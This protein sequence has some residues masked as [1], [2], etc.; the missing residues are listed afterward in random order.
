MKSRI[1]TARDTHFSILPV[2]CNY[3]RSDNPVGLASFLREDTSVVSQPPTGHSF[4]NSTRDHHHALH[5]LPTV[6]AV[7]LAARFHSDYFSNN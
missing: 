6:T 3:V 5:P 2:P 7:A 4:F 1:F